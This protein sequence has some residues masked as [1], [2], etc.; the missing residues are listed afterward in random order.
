MRGYPEAAR[1]DPSLTRSAIL[2]ALPGLHSQVPGYKRHPRGQIRRPEPREACS[3][4][5][6]RWHRVG[7]MHPARA[8][9]VHPLVGIRKVGE[10]DP[11]RDDVT[12]VGHRRETALIERARLLSIHTVTG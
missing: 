7:W 9:T 4:K 8:D 1:D 2:T 6:V 5:L 12:N 10:D 3:G 11:W